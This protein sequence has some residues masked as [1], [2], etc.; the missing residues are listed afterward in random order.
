M[1]DEE[2]NL[3]S[4][5]DG[6]VFL[7]CPP[8]QESSGGH[9]DTSAANGAAPRGK[10]FGAKK[11]RGSPATTHG[12]LSQVPVIASFDERVVDRETIN[13]LAS[14]AW[15]HVDLAVEKNG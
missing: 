8:R 9:A 11:A 4:L 7:V 15:R 12:A 1:T 6:S 13:T 14:N 10:P 5:S 2:Y 3:E